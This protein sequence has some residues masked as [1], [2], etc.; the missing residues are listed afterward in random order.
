MCVVF[1]QVSTLHARLRAD[2]ESV[3]ADTITAS[4]T[5]MEKLMNYAGTLVTDIGLHIQLHITEAGTGADSMS[6]LMT[7]CSAMS[8]TAHLVG[9][10][11]LLSVYGD[12]YNSLLSQHDDGS[13]TRFTLESVRV[14]V[15]AI[16]GLVASL[17]VMDAVSTNSEANL[18]TARQLIKRDLA[19]HMHPKLLAIVNAASLTP[20]STCA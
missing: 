14:L 17:A 12:Q 19:K 1:A 20:A 5:C 15:N 9:L 2:V 16:N 3:Q 4:H 6:T 7:S 18:S 13:V 10:S 8:G 11:K